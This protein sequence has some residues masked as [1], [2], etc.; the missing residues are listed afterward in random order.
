MYVDPDV[1]AVYR[2]LDLTGVFINGVIGGTI[3][4]QKKF[5]LIGFAFLALISALGGGLL[6]DVFMQK[7]TPT[8]F[9]EPI[10][11]GFALLGGLI[12]WIAGL[13]GRVWRTLF[14][15]GDAIVLGVWSVTGSMKAL[16]L[17]LPWPSAILCG[18]ITAVGGGMIRDIALGNVPIIFGGNNMYATPAVLGASI[19]AAFHQFE[20]P[21]T[22]GMLVAA[23]VSSSIAILAAWR[24]WTLPQSSDTA[25]ITMTRRQLRRMLANRERLGLDKERRRWRRAQ[26]RDSDIE[27]PE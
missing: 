26:D 16:S 12:A 20:L 4:R 7:G 6:R 10:Y 25:P 11:L 27:S 18:M 17:G 21:M 13:E 8:A 14:G 9:A 15:G 1:D 19:M 3:A 24:K 5:D 22:T 23:A 2:I